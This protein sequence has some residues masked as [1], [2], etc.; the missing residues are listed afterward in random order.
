MKNINLYFYLFL[1]S[2]ITTSCEVIK[3]I[4]KAGVWVGIVGVVLVIGLVLFIFG[5]MKG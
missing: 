3:D 5:K 4:F 2:F 1:I